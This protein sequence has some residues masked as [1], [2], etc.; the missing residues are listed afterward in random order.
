MSSHPKE[1]CCEI[2]SSAIV[3]DVTAGGPTTGRRTGTCRSGDENERCRSSRA[4]V[5]AHDGGVDHL[6]AAL[7]FAALVRSRKQHIRDPR[8]RPAPKLPADRAPLAEMIVQ[9]TPPRA[10]PRNPEHPS[11]ARRCSPGRRPAAV[12]FELQTAQRT[13]TPHPTS[14]HEPSRCPQSSLEPVIGVGTR[15]RQHGLALLWQVNLLAS[16]RF[17]SAPDGG[18]GAV[19]WMDVTAGG[20]AI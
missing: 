19:A 17:D 10:R 8:E 7:T 13:P 6:D 18:S 12:P 16:L 3:T 1:Q 15:L 11:S 4:L 14:G 9:V 5:G 2:S 20:V